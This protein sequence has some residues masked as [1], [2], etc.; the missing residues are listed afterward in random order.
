MLYIYNFIFIADSGDKEFPIDKPVYVIW[1]LG[2]LDKINNEPSFHDLYPRGDVVLELNRKEAEN[3]C[4]DFTEIS[5][6]LSRKC[7]EFKTFLY[8]IIELRFFYFNHVFHSLFREPWEKTEII[9]RSVRTFRATIGPSGGK[10]GYQGIT[11]IN[12]LI[13]LDS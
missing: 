6:K 9:D 8:F 7:E 3:T 2:R 1:A 4:I 11:G 13:L 10:K 12:F 5:S